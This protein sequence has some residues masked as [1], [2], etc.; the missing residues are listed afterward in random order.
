MPLF[1][2]SPLPGTPF[3]EF[4]LRCHLLHAGFPG[5]IKSIQSAM[6]D[7]LEYL[8]PTAQSIIICVL[9]SSPHCQAGLTHLFPG[10]QL[11]AW[12]PSGAQ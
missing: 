4:Y 12:F 3:P 9:S 2:L 6:F 11:S 5:L 8:T 1:L 10:A 7:S